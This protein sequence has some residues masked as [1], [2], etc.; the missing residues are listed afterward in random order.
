MGVQGKGRVVGEQVGVLGVEG[1]DRLVDGGGEGQAVFGGGVGQDLVAHH[2]GGDGITHGFGGVDEGEVEFR[3]G[4]VVHFDEAGGF[5][6]GTDLVHGLRAVV[7]GLFEHVHD[8]RGEGGRDVGGERGGVQLGVQA[9][10]LHDAA[11]SAEWVGSR[12]D[13]VEHDA[14]RVD[15]T[16]AVGALFAAELFG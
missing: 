1:V 10:G 3:G 11:R 16:A 9:H 7:R 8:E 5:E 14:E 6:V 13:A 12:E 4:A 2:P 15:V